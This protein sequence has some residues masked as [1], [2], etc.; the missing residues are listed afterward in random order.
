M[1]TELQLLRAEIASL[2]AQLADQDDFMAY[3]T[4]ELAGFKCMHEDGTH[5]STPPM[6]WP[7]LVACIRARGIKDALAKVTQ[8]TKESGDAD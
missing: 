6:F 2:R 4:A 8:E 7:E 5:D 3:M 1:Q